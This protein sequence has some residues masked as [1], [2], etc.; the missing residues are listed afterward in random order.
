VGDAPVRLFAGWTFRP[1]GV[2]TVAAVAFC[3]L[4]VLL[5]NWQLR[6]AAEKEALQAE[7]EAAARAAPIA[8]PAQPVDGQAWAWRRVVARGEFAGGRSI[9]LD[10]RTR[11]GRAGYEVLTPLR[12]DGSDRYVLINRG[13][14]AY[15]GSREALPEIGVPSGRVQVEGI[16]I[17]PPEK[18]FTLGAPAAEDRVWQ[19]LDLARYQEWSGLAVQPVVVLQTSDSD[20]GLLR[21]WPRPELGADKHRAY[22]VQWYSFAFLTV[23]LYVALNFKRVGAG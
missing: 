22:A 18:V 3:I 15:S 4:S 2:T 13:W 16:A 23:V 17:I 9:F 1:R 10:N 8:L 5:G 14:V 7:R 20:D 6:R 12:I 19:H 21:R 11:E